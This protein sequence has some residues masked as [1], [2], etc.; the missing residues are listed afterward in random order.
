MARYLT[1]VRDTLQRFTEWTIEKIRRTKNGRT[2]AL[3]GIATSLPIKEAILLPIHVQ[4]NPSVAEAST[5]NTI[6]A[7]QADGQ[8]WTNDIIGYLR[9]GTLPEDTKQTHKIRVQAA[10]F[11]LI[12]GHLY[13]RSFTGPYLLCLNH[14]EALYVL[15]EL[16]EG[17]CGNHSRGRSLAYRAHS[18]GYYWPTMKKDAAAYVKKCDKCQRH[19]PVPHVPSETLKPISGPW[20][21]AQ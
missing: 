11:T 13:K 14:S 8:E 21:F 20:P 2:D 5:C 10:R 16:H 15:A 1:K 18:Q 7:K 19:A 4:T 9:T 17:V 12:G 3:A 6:E